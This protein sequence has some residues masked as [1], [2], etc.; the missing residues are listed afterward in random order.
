MTLP[1]ARIEPEL[2]WVALPSHEVT[3]SLHL[4]APEAS[5]LLSPSHSY[6]FP[7]LP[8]ASACLSIEP[9]FCSTHEEE[10]T[11][12]STLFLAASLKG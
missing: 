2:I 11:Y 1:D 9:P 10:K 12:P 5:P 6:P 7:S 3:T 8:F 4:I